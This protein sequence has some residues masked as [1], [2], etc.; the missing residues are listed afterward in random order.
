M[1]IPREGTTMTAAAYT[2]RA[3]GWARALE[4]REAARNGMT[5]ADAR[6]AVSRRLAVPAGTL[7]NLRKNRL[8]AIAAHWY[9]KLRSGVVRELEAELRHVE[10]ELNIARQIG[11][12]P[13][14]GEAHALLATEARLREA[15]GLSLAGDRRVS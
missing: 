3:R 12:D 7:E 8:K 5:I 11:L 15:L 4:D 9:E 10:H 14:S 6:E 1:R 2:D 13:A